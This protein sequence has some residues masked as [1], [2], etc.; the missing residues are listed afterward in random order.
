MKEEVQI[1]FSPEFPKGAE[2]LYVII[3]TRY[4]NR[5]LFVRHKER[6][7]WEIP[8]GHIE[9]GEEPFAAA[10]RELFEETGAVQYDLRQITAYTVSMRDGV[11]GG[12]I[13]LATVTGLAGLPPEHEIA[14]YVLRDALP[15][16]LTY[17]EIQPQIFNYMQGWLN[18]QSNALE[19]WDIYDG[20][21][22][23]TGRTHRRGDPLPQGDYHIVVGVWIFDTSTNKYLITKRSPNKGFANLW[24]NTGGSALSGDDSLSA[25]LRE[26]REETGLVLFPEN[27]RQVLSLK[28]PSDFHDVWLFRQPVN[29]A[30]VVLQ[31]GETADARLASKEEIIEM[32]HSGDF[33]PIHYLEDFIALF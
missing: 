20:H 19:L 12:Y 13:Y 31:E 18:L 1:A 29:L 6:A 23:P 26:V 10:G 25:A 3:L 2:L 32:I 14:E 24:E 16:R 4:Q 30:D 22:R 11:K 27:G 17:P 7:T 5:W 21:R 9:P 8:G 28:A 33:V 15:E